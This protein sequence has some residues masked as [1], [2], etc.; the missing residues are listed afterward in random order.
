MPLTC[1][2]PP[3]YYPACMQALKVKKLDARAHLPERA[4]H[5]DLGYD[6]FSLDQALIP[7]GAMR[8][9]RTGIALEFPEGWGGIIKDRSSMAMKRITTSAGVI[10]HGYRGEIVVLLTNNSELDFHIEP[11]QKIAQM[12]PTRVADWDIIEVKELNDTQ[13]GAS[14]FGSTGVGRLAAGG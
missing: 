1:G 10:D 9:V 14:G 13:R 3:V 11:G 8:P 6:L 4:N 7:R 2:P 12:T 5:G